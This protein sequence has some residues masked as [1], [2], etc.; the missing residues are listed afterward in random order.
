MYSNASERPSVR[1]GF[2]YP[3]RFTLHSSFFLT[4]GK[5]RLFTEYFKWVS[6]SLL[7][8]ALPAGRWYWGGYNPRSE[9]DLYS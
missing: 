8:S 3:Y 9:L 2:V 4:S 1:C 7:K 6:S 5:R